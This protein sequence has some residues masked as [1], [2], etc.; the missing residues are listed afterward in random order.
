MDTVQRLIKKGVFDEHFLAHQARARQMTEAILQ[1]Y[2]LK[3]GD[4]RHRF[5]KAWFRRRPYIQWYWE[6]L[7]ILTTSKKQWTQEL[8]GE[9]TWDAEA[10]VG[11]FRLKVRHINRTAEQV[12]IVKMNEIPDKIRRLAW[13]V[14]YKFLQVN[15]RRM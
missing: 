12:Q 1:N 3:N 4:L 5:Y 15:A 8:G 6:G 2:Q 9:F 14:W 11:P 13:F 7:P 10:I